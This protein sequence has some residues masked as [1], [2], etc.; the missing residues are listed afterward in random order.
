M[1]TYI[2]IYIY[3]YM[4]ICSE[5]HG[6]FEVTITANVPWRHEGGARRSFEGGTT[7]PGSSV[8]IMIYYSTNRNIIPLT[9]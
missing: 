9:N 3:I 4:Y 5:P 2:Y 6:G 1:Y 7:P 8:A